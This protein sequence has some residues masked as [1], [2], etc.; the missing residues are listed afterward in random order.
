MPVI[1][2]VLYQLCVANP[3]KNEATALVSLSLAFGKHPFTFLI[4]SRLISRIEP[5][6]RSLRHHRFRTRHHTNTAR[7]IITPRGR[8]AKYSR[9]SQQGR[10]DIL[11]SH[12]LV[13]SL[14]YGSVFCG[15]GRSFA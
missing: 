10:G 1:P 12:S 5:S 9:D 3:G 2:L 14:G 15:E 7:Q 6:V 11:C 13:S 8:C 4:A